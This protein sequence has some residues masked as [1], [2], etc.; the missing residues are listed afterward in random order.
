MQWSE[1]SWLGSLLGKPC[2]NLLNV[3]GLT[4]GIPLFKGST[5][6]FLSAKIPSANF[7]VIHALENSNFQLVDTNLSL[8]LKDF[9]TV[10]NNKARQSSPEDETAVREIAAKSFRSSR[11]HNDPAIADEVAD[12]I[13]A[14]WA[15]NF[16]A[17]NRG[18][19]LIVTERN[20]EIAGFLLVLKREE[21]VIIDL[22]AVDER[23]RNQGC[24]REMIGFLWQ[25]LGDEFS[26]IIVGTQLSNAS[27]LNFYQNLGFRLDSSAYV[28]HKHIQ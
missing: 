16:F 13:K 14:Q 8:V 20:G 11:F 27:S 17:G 2:F 15:G 18:D 9:G 12:N 4:V 28:Y 7:S 5:P 19:C 10:R 1:D 6:A 25:Y 23:F 24:G 22:I 21:N 3:P 26:Q